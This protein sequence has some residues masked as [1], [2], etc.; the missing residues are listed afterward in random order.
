MNIWKCFQGFIVVENITDDINKI[1]TEENI[2][3]TTVNDILQNIANFSD[4]LNDNIKYYEDSPIFKKDCYI[5]LT[6][7]LETKEDVGII[8]DYFDNWIH[9]EGQLQL[10]VLGDYGTGKSTVAKR[11]AY[12]QAKKYLGNPE[13][14]RIPILI[15]LKIYQKSISIESLVTDLLINQYSVEIKNFN[16]FKHLNESGKLLIILDGFDE[17]ASR[18]DL[19]VTLAN[20][21]E[22][23]KLISEKSKVIL[24]CRTHYFKNQDEIHKLHEGTEIY[25]KID[26]KGGYSFLFLNP[27]KEEDFIIYLE[28]FF[29]DDWKKYYETIINTYNLRELAEK[30]ILLE[31][32]VQT[33]PQI[34]I[35]ENEKLNHASLY[36]RYTKFWLN[37]D[38]WRSYLTTNDRELITEE[39]AFYLFINDKDKIFY[40]ELPKIIQE[41]FQDKRTVEIDILDQDVRTCTFLNRDERGDYSFVHQSFMEFFV[42]KKLLNEIKNNNSDN[43]R[44]KRLPQEIIG[45]LANLAD[46]VDIFHNYIKFTENKSFQEVKYLGGNSA[47]IANLMGADFSEMDMS[48]TVLVGANF[49]AAKL[50]N[51]NLSNSILGMKIEPTTNIMENKYTELK[52]L[53]DELDKYA[54]IIINGDKINKKQIK[55]KIDELISHYPG[56]ID[57]KKIP[58]FLQSIIRMGHKKQ[59]ITDEDFSADNIF[60]N[61]L[62]NKFRLHNASKEKSIF[63]TLN[64][65]LNE[66]SVFTTFVKANLQKANLNNC[67]LRE[68]DLRDVN[69]RG[70][71]LVGAKLSG[72]NLSRTD[73]RDTDLR[74]ADLRK[75]DLKE[76]NLS[77]ALLIRAK[78]N[79]A[80]LSNANLME[81][82]LREANLI[83][84]RLIGANLSKANLKGAIR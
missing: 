58:M 75:T 17:M 41:H 80:N 64:A 50:V 31:L 25:N 4:Y 63:D 83:G 33:L 43:F 19:N 38:D 37:R 78:L 34:K 53:D 8:D 13:N 57:D 73:L 9:S 36:D 6:A 39:L 82:D 67:D 55:D 29:T 30:P 22:F 3:V 40:E 66:K 35:E 45:F 14:E 15:E 5:P 62:I 32:M 61:S 1:I 54:N 59:K 11:L 52:Y 12:R 47:T 65:T 10:T 49:D 42:A 76:A 72:L 77:G 84:S 16:A 20:F 68:V 7:N 21:R 48:S 81:V 24:T 71:S 27:F 2:K 18:V 46:N 74:E 44:L 60:F 69:L 51:S 23:D 56:D 28:K 79:S 26:E 70:A